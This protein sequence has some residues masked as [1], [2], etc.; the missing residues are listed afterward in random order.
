MLN[1]EFTHD[2]GNWST[3]HSRVSVQKKLA[4][5]LWASCQKMSNC[6]LASSQFLR[7]LSS[8]QINDKWILYQD[9]FRVQFNYSQID[10][11]LNSIQKIV[12]EKM[13]GFKTESR[14]RQN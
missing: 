14:L 4:D 3:A 11:I 10:F 12:G 6:L 9:A 5:F 2:I 8:T 1:C 7:E 13:N